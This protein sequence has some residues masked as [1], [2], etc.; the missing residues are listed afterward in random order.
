MRKVSNNYNHLKNLK[1]AGSSDKEIKNIEIFIGLD[2]YYQ[3]VTG[4]IIR[5]KS[6]EAIAL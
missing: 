5:G 3:I 2:Y 1:L 6:N 4:E